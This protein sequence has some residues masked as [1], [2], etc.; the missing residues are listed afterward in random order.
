MSIKRTPILGIAFLIL[1]FV[2][3]CNQESSLDPNDGLLTLPEGFPEIPFPDGN[4]FTYDRWLL[5]KKLFFDPVLSIDSS[6]SCGS[7]HKPALAFADNLATTPGA[8]D[9]PGV[10]NAPGLANIAW[11][12]YM[13]REGSVPTLEMQILVPIQ[14]ENEFAHNI[15]DIS[16]ELQLDAEYVKMSE[17]AYGRLPDPFVITRAI[18]TFERTLI[19]GN[20]PYDQFEYQDHRGSLT[21]EQKRGKELFFSEETGCSHCHSGFNFTNYEFENNGLYLNYEDEGRMRLTNDSA[22][23]ARFKVPSL[24]NSSVTAPYMHDGSIST[25]MEVIEHYNGGGAVHPNKSELVRPLGLTFQE[26]QELLSFLES[27]TDLE[28]INDARFRP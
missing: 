4:E 23:L 1:L 8:M 22:D 10:R 5:G 13:L 17:A 12:P 26:K 16:E 11:H 14:E 2:G 25:L 24:R 7:C 19:S 21:E 28:F 20:S 9:Q 15:V 3:A 6:V 18:S 27:L